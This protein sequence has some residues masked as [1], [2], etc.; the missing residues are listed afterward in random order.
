[1]PVGGL[2]GEVSRMRESLS[3]K[4]ACSCRPRNCPGLKLFAGIQLHGHHADPAGILGAVTATRHCNLQCAPMEQACSN[5]G[6]RAGAI[7]PPKVTT[8]GLLEP[9]VS[10]ESGTCSYVSGRCKPSDAVLFQPAG[11]RPTLWRPAGNCFKWTIS[12]AVVFIPKQW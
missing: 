10:W 7:R 5:Y 1:M 11:L 9:F 3:S 4:A 6:F 2:G 12:V 8:W